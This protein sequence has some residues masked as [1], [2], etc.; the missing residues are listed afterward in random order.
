MTRPRSHTLI[1]LGLLVVTAAMP[2]L[3][4]T[5]TVAQEASP[6]SPAS[7][8][9]SGASASPSP[10]AGTVPVLSLPVMPDDADLVR[11]ASTTVIDTPV[12]PTEGV[13]L[14]QIAAT[15][16]AQVGSMR[17]SAWD[18]EAL[19]DSF[20][21]D[22]ARAFAFV[23]DSI[24]LDS[25]RGSLRGAEGTLAA[26]AGNDVDRAMLLKSLLDSMSLTARYSTGTL[27]D[28][29]VASLGARIF[30]APAIAL[31]DGRAAALGT[32]DVA[33]VGARATRDA[34]LLRTMLGTRID[35]LGA[36]TLADLADELRDHT[37]V[38]LRWGTGWLDYDPSLPGS[39]PGATLAAATST[40]P[41]LSPDTAQTVRISLVAESLAGTSLTETTVLDQTFDAADAA[42]RRIFLYFQPELAGI[43]GSVV[44]T[45]EGIDTWQPIL[46]VDDAATA[47]SAFA[48][49]GR[50][51]DLFGD[52][53]DAPQL[54]GLRLTV[55]RAGAG[56]APESA[57]HVLL[58]RVPADARS[59]GSI[60]SELLA[61]LP[62][63]DEGGPLVMGGM[64]HVQVSTGGADARWAAARRGI[65]ADFSA[66]AFAT[67][68]PT[69][70]RALGDILY[71]VAVADDGLLLGSEQL[72]VAA[73]NDPGR[74]RAWVARPRI[75][76]SVMGQ[77]PTEVEDMAFTTDLLLDDVRVIA[78]DS[79]STGEAARRTI[80][81]G[82]L[83]SALESE[84]ALRR[85]AGLGDA[86]E[87]L[88]GASFAMG[89][90]L[91]V[92]PDSGALPAEAPAALRGAVGAG[93]LVVVAGEPGSAV[94][95]WTIDPATAATRSVLDPG[96]G[97]VH[98]K[99]AWGSIRH[100]PPNLNRGGAGGANTWYHNRDGSITRTPRPSGGGTPQGPPPSRCG[101][102]S[103][104]MTILG[105]VSI[106]A[107]WAIRVGLGLVIT[108]ILWIAAMRLLM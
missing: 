76:L 54:T 77:D 9:P 27:D 62:T 65:A 16:A 42:K 26:R 88:V 96:L 72:A 57:T 40:S 59:M 84:L 78:A 71:P 70:G 4:G 99:V 25:Y 91:T 21:G 7:G 105:C 5:A 68:E 101:S 73:A 98:G 52:P 23:R 15:A 49:G 48:A 20:D 2:L 41:T 43:G 22:P 1:T 100:R 87:P 102:G 108:E 63:T 79:A 92:I 93:D 64:T 97:G 55:T 31:E 28:Q 18:L 37:W 19:A 83:E 8:A 30:A 95:W 46:L 69:E 67:D 47:G 58:D 82:A 14:E 6:S 53:V 80:W 89:E 106:P 36:S 104:Y 90:K 45:L 12:F 85:A 74:V 11:A 51:T 39:V 13:D 24:G 34:A 33:A 29:A 86:V 60:G 66:G 50:G 75:F 103:E 32:L 38:Q 3:D 81:Y 107:A 56:L 10:P 61:P 17:S 94:T 44:H 35:R